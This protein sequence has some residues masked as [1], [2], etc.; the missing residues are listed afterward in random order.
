MSHAPSSSPAPV[1]RSTRLRGLTLPRPSPFPSRT[2][3]PWRPVR[4]AAPRTPLTRAF[5]TCADTRSRRYR[6][7]CPRRRERATVPFCDV[8][9]STGIGE[10]Q[11]PERVRGVMSR[12]FE[13]ARTV[14]ERHGGTIE[15]FIG[16]A[17]MAVFGIPTLHEDD[18]V[19]AVRAAVE[20]RDAVARL[21][22]ELERALGLKIA[23]RT[24]VNTGEVIAG[25]PTHA[26]SFVA[27][28]A[29]NVAQRLQAAAAPGEILIGE[30]TYRLARDAVA[31]DA[32][33]QLEVKGKSAP[34]VAYRLLEVIPHAA[35]DARRLDSP[36][37][38]RERELEA[39]RLAFEGTVERAECGLVTILGPA[40]V[41]KSRL[42]AEALRE[43]V[44][45]A[46][47]LS[48]SCLAYGEGITFW[49]ISKSCARRWASPTTT[50]RLLRLGRSPR[51][52][53][54]RSRGPRR[55]ACRRA[56]RV[57][58]GRSGRRRGLLGRAQAVRDTRPEKRPLV[59]V[60]TISTGPSRR[61][62][63]WSSTSSAGRTGR[64]W[65][66]W[67][68][69]ATSCSSCARAGRGARRPRSR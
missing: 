19:R 63:T 56:D 18:P 30:Q 13:E 35:G 39:V 11:D 26:Q 43:I 17:V 64:R 4:A 55:R 45:R 14:L 1:R 58:G 65:C 38:G 68:W 37:V 67:R 24:G 59:I 46:T 69:P 42:A 62:S 48:G 2:V 41:G 57:R 10:H 44:L 29:V 52:S 40:G 36:M 3:R 33:E 54:A 47:V 34:V 27:G 15:K 32:V 61:C 7:P 5:A 31:A 8:V 66:S 49:P 12:V 6:R 50:T 25:D 51:H 16:D 9:D 53:R 23:V 60:L 21:N 28:D 20:L 22:E